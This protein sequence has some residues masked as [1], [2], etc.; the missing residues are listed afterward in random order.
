MMLS[1][2]FCVLVCLKGLQSAPA[3]ENSKKPICSSHSGLCDVTFEIQQNSGYGRQM[4]YTSSSAICSCPGRTKCPRNI[5]DNARVF[6]QELSSPDQIIKTRLSYC[7][8]Q[9]FTKKVCKP[10]ELSLTLRGVGPIIA[11]I[12]GDVRCKCNQPLALHRAM[13]DGIYSKREYTCGRPTCNVNRTKRD[14]CERIVMAATMFGISTSS[15][16][17]CECPEGYQC[18]TDNPNTMSAMLGRPTNFYCK[19]LEKWNGNTF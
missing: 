3:W 2:I 15:E 5:T 18:S 12:V 13:P 7:R 17:P 19:M 8:R 10:N 9:T 14:V 6:Y 1:T 11:E 4:T 16:I